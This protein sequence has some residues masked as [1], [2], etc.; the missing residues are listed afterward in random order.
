MSKLKTIDNKQKTGK[1]NEINLIWKT[2]LFKLF[3]FLIF[4]LSGD[5]VFDTRVFSRK[6]KDT[7][8]SPKDVLFRTH[9]YE[10][11]IEPSLDFFSH[12]KKVKGFL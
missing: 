4:S 7:E 5:F 10:F 3:L 9:N 1:Q 2:T 6:I 12:F 11:Y 8:E